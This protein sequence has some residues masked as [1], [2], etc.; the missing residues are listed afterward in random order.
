MPRARPWRPTLRCDRC[1]RIRPRAALL[2]WLMQPPAAD[3]GRI[4]F[5]CRACREALA[6]SR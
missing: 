2:A 6:R 5:L 1:G 4:H 3:G